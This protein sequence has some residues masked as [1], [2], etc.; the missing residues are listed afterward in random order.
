MRLRLGIGSTECCGI[1][2][3]PYYA[4]GLNS[5]H[6]SYL[7]PLGPPTLPKGTALDPFAVFSRISRL[8]VVMPVFQEAS[9]V[10]DAIL[11]V[12]SS[13]RENTELELIIVESG[14]TDG[15][16]DIVKEFASDS[17]VV[18]IFQDKPYGKGNA[19]RQGFAAASGEVI[20]IFDADG[21]YEF[22]D[23]WSLVRPIEDGTTS[24]VLGSRHSKGRPMRSFEEARWMAAAMNL[25]HWVFASM[26]NIAFSARLRDPFTMWKVFRA[27]LVAA[28]DLRA[29]RFDLDWEM[30]GRF[31][32][33]GALPVEIPAQYCSRDYAHGKKVR[34]LRDPLSW[35]AILLK[36]RLGH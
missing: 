10:R 25:M 34:L 16:R 18:L 11:Q 2:T 17:R 5:C 36:I 32:L 8:S 29:N 24:F 23:I 27:E 7:A 33:A 26:I 19:V 12:L 9:T 21:E 28:V 20:T 31:I 3:P 15:S 22:A 30:V 13:P 35:M 6:S 1:H 4:A 14:S